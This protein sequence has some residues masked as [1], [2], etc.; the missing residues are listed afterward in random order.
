MK[1][2]II[3][4]LIIIVLLIVIRLC[5][6]KIKN[7][8]EGGAQFA[9]P[10]LGKAF[11]TEA[12]LN[13]MIAEATDSELKY[14]DYRGD[15]YYVRYEGD[16]FRIEKDTESDE[17][18]REYNK[19]KAITEGGFHIIEGGNAMAR[20]KNFNRNMKHIKVWSKTDNKYKSI[21]MNQGITELEEVNS[22]KE[23]YDYMSKKLPTGDNVLN[24]LIVI[25]SLGH[26]GKSRATKIIY[27][28]EGGKTKVIKDIGILK[29]K[30][31]FEIWE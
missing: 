11:K 24:R 28:Y 16:D 12:L 2:V 23:L 27:E 6:L 8:D 18:L 29:Y 25:V 3:A 7:S 22:I 21:I 20:I 26:I 17:T 1:T 13:F 10:G 9:K 4:G 14:I 31:L 15:V 30:E 5:V 19:E